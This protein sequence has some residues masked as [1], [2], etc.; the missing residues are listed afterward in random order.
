M[1]ND[2]SLSQFGLAHTN[3]V[4]RG[5]SYHE[6]GNYSESIRDYTTAIELSPDVAKTYY[7]RA[8]SYQKLEN[9]DLAQLDLTKARELGL[10]SLP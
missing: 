5:M 4:N 7:L 8:L 1:E 3:L 6:I 10:Q 9:A 2:H